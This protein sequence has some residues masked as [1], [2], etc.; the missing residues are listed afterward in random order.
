MTDSKDRRILVVDDDAAIRQSFEK[1]FTRKGYS[2]RTAESGEE[3]LRLMNEEPTWVH[4]L[5][6]RMDGMNGIELCRA[7]KERW[8]MTICHAVTGYASLFE[9]ADAR[10][11]GFEDYFEKPVAL[12]DLFEA[13]EIAFKRVERWRS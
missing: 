12:E 13:A 1:A 5:D 2:V 9:L 10:A 6:L 7:L 3:A 8:P 4:F 11:A